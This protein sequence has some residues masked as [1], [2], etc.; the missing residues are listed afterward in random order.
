MPIKAYATTV[1]PETAKSL[2]VEDKEIL[3]TLGDQDKAVAV[4]LQELFSSVVESIT[5]SLEVESQLVVEITGSVSLKAQGSTKYLFFNVGAEAGATGT[6]KVALTTT[7]K[8]KAE[9]KLGDKSK[10]TEK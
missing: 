10:K 1:S 4:Q 2:K 8:P 9:I 5:A 7:L 6:M 3:K